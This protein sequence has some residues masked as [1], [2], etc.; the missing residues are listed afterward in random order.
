MEQYYGMTPVLITTPNGGPKKVLD[1]RTRL[2]YTSFSESKV[3]DGEILRIDLLGQRLIQ[4]SIGIGP[5][6]DA[7]IKDIFSFSANEKILVGLS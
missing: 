5:I 1:F 4:D 6:I 2:E 3:M 7:N